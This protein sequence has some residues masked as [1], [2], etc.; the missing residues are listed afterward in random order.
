MNSL[1]NAFISIFEHFIRN[2]SNYTLI[3]GLLLVLN[4][5]FQRF[6]TDIGFLFVGILLLLTSVVLEINNVNGKRK[7]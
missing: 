4:F 1:I 2:L 7:R 5:V 3:S 6:G